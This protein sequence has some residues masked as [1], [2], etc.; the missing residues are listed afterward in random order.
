MATY[1]IVAP[2]NRNEFEEVLPRRQG[3]REAPVAAAISPAIPISA[4]R[5]DLFSEA[6][7]EMSSTRQNR[8]AKDALISVVFHAV[9]LTALLVAPLYF[10]D[11][12]DMTRFA[13]TFLVAPLPP[14]PPPPPMAQNLVKSVATPKRMLISNGKLLAPT[15]IPQKV[16]ILKEEPPPDLGEGVAGGVPGGVPGGQM[17]GV[18]GGIISGSTHTSV[19]MPVPASSPKAPMRVGG[20]IKPPRVLQAPAPKYPVLARQSNLEGK[21]LLDAVID[22]QGNV[23]EVQ[24]VSGHPL[25]INAALDAVRQWKYE[26]TY[27]NDQ[28]I[29]VKLFVTVTFQLSR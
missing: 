8:S 11:R 27:L 1:P 21:V 22:A 19:P 6:L 20:R 25:L 10:T 7:L 16:T 2:P 12:I 13:Q 18:I 15:V 23:T 4:H 9:V 5:S 28:A 17:G 29:S 3:A 26:P 24:V 14:P